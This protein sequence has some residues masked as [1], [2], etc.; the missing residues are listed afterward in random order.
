MYTEKGG[1]EFR[2][3]K[4]RNSF[5]GSERRK[6]FDKARES[7]GEGS[8]DIDS[9][10]TKRGET[11]QA[12]LKLSSADLTDLSFYGPQAASRARKLRRGTL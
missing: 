12:E 10:G 7:R 5:N 3:G 4:R 9:G 1:A 11:A 6:S 2:G 8:R